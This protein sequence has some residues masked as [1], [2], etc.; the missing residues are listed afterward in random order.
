MVTKG[1]VERKKEETKQKIISTALRLFRQFGFNA[2]TMEQIA[3]EA[4]IAKGTLYNY[5]PVKEEILSE[6]IKTSFSQK[7]PGRIEHMKSLADTKARM[8][9]ILH[10]LIEGVKAQKEIFEKYLTYRIQKVISL[11]KD[12]DAKSGIESLSNEIIRLGQQDGEIRSDIENGIIMDLFEFVFIEAAKQFY[13]NPEQFDEEKTIGLCVEL[14]L[15]AVKP[16]P[17]RRSTK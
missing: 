6:Y 11:E 5:F 17:K 14:F 9:L 16:T 8:E 4:D 7:N 3:N 15:N 1:R 2:A 12:K 10:E 13:T